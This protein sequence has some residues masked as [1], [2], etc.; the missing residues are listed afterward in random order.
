MCTNLDFLKEIGIIKSKYCMS[1]N[2][3]ILEGTYAHH[4]T[5][6]TTYKWKLL[7]VEFG[8]SHHFTSV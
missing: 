1:V 2:L 5:T 6:N 8:S 4:Y 3:F 7:I